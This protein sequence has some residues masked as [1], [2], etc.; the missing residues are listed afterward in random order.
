[1]GHSLVSN[2]GHE[3]VQWWCGNNNSLLRLSREEQPSGRSPEWHHS[4]L[5]QLAQR[6]FRTYPAS[7]NGQMVPANSGDFN[8]KQPYRYAFR[9]TQMQA[10]PAGTR[11][12]VQTQP[13]YHPGARR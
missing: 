9:V 13:C 11:R 2:A 6:M 8:V 10:A 4:E 3:H 5:T 12:D 1:M 7:N